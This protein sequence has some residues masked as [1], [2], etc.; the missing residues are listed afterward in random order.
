MNGLTKAE[1]A[2]VLGVDVRSVARYQQRG[3]PSTRDSQG[4][5]IFDVFAVR[6][7]LE[8]EGIPIREPEQGYST[9][10]TAPAAPP[11]DYQPTVSKDAMQRAE[12]ARKLSIARKNELEIQSEKGLK[13]LGL[14]QK[15]RGAKTLSQL[16]EV[17]SEFAAF[18]S[19]GE[20]LPQR[21]HAL[22]QTLNVLE[23]ALR[24]KEAETKDDG[25]I[26]LM[27]EQGRVIAETL[28]KIG[29]GWRRRWLL[30]AAA[31]H[32]AE[33]EK[34]IPGFEYDMT[35]TLAGLEIDL[36]GEPIG[37]AWPTYLSPPTVPA[38]LPPPAPP[39]GS[40]VDL[41]HAAESTSDSAEAAP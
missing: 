17:C 7:W 8:A 6:R 38:F 20:I 18:V 1:L 39:S 28:D 25:R 32:L 10:A 14:D 2:R 12:L 24:A 35:E 40:R 37:A 19:S 36:M 31:L 13:D 9:G 34:E 3:C 33:D 11:Q 41:P 27:T 21:S 26:F 4:R 29:N 30:E 22:R 16:A 15:I 5:V 23:R